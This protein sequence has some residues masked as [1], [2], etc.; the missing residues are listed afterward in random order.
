MQIKDSVGEEQLKSWK[1]NWIDENKEIIFKRLTF[2][3]VS[4]DRCSQ[5][6]FNQ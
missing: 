1:K 3:K 5:I 4:G 2:C 6:P